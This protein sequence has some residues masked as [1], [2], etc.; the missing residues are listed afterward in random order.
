[1]AFWAG[2]TFAVVG[3]VLYW[4]AGVMYVR[5]TIEVARE[6]RKSLDGPS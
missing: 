2:W 6:H 1:M 5:R 4:T 3:V